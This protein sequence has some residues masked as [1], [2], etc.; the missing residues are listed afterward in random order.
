MW[1]PTALASEAR[2][3]GGVVWRVVEHQYTASTRKIVARQSDQDILE[4]LLE[5]S[6]PRVPAPCRHLDYLLYSPFRYRATHPGSRF[7]LPAPGDGVFYAAEHRVTAQAE[8]TYWRLRFFAA[9]PD[10]PLPRQEERLTAF[11]AAYRT[12]RAIDLTTPAFSSDRQAWTDPCDYSATQ[13][14]ALQAR[15]AGVEMIRY[16]SVRDPNRWANIALLGCASFDHPTPVS[17]QTWYLY[18]GQ[19]EASWRRAQGTRAERARFDVGA[20]DLCQS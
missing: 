3:A 10:T 5:E 16:E 6:K 7:R 18:L 15:R 8:F 12:E 9:S 19:E 14:L 2:A 17:Q 1:T 4:D 13:A 11:S 20:F